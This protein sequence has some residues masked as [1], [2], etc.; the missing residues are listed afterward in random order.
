MC[1]IGGGEFVATKK[2]EYKN[3]VAAAALAGECCV[4]GK[5]NAA[6]YCTNTDV[7]AKKL[8]TE[9]KQPEIAIASCPNLK[10]NCDG[11]PTIDLDAKAD[12]ENRTVGGDAIKFT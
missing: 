5:T 4:Y 6:N 10:A 12:A 3:S 8:S 2:E 11:E 7:S 1:I 9:F